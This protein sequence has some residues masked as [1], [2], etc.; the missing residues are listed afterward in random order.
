MHHT[1]I[2]SVTNAPFMRAFKGWRKVCQKAHLRKASSERCTDKVRESL[3]S[4]MDSMPVTVSSSA[5]GIAGVDW[6]FSVAP[7]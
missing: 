1:S 2:A 3:S 6:W 4:Q 7:L 5:H